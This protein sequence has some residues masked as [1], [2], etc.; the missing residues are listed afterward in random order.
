MR[1]ITGIAVTALVATMVTATTPGMALAAD[2][3][4]PTAVDLAV[5][6]GR[7]NDRTLDGGS[8]SGDG[9]YVAF[10]SFAS[11]LVSDDRNGRLDVFVRNTATGGTTLVSVGSTGEQANEP[12][13]EPS[14]SADGRYVAFWSAASNLVPGDTNEADDVFVRDLQAGTTTR[15][16]VTAG[17]AAGGWHDDS[18]FPSI[19]GDG[20]YIAFETESRLVPTD[21]DWWTDVYVYDRVTGTPERVT[22]TPSGRPADRHTYWAGTRISGDGRF[23][24]FASEAANLVAG[25]TNG[26]KDVFVRDRQEDVTRLISVTAAGV[27][28]NG[29]SEEPAISVD[30]RL[31]AFRSSATNLGE[32][33]DGGQITAKVYVKDLRTGELTRED[34]NT[35]GAFVGAQ[36]PQLS[37]DG[38]YLAVTASSGAME[39]DWS[40]GRNV[41][42][43]D[44]QTGAVT[45]ASHG[46]TGKPAVR[47]CLDLALSADGRRVTFVS[48]DGTL[49]AGDTDRRD[50]LFLTTVPN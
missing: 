15:V 19:S 40:G 36:E 9:R 23:V 45:P 32:G 8:L 2:A 20:R 42:V 50:N 33:A 28:G 13:S 24:V 48:D 1:R 10:S 16:S 22:V 43:R 38:R 37:G 6:G 34:R 21:T 35:A 11:N 47:A 31:A 30:G 3:I 29:T 14:I 26:K 17:G 41:Y 7:P 5:D 44:R 25:D 4:V 18:R 27:Q 12:S 49:V 39:G 46:I